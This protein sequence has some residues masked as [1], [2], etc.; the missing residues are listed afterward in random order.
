MEISINFIWVERNNEWQIPEDWD[1][2]ANDDPVSENLNEVADD[3]D[4]DQNLELIFNQFVTPPNFLRNPQFDSTFL[5]LMFKEGAKSSAT[6][7]L[8]PS[9]WVELAKKLQAEDINPSVI[10]VPH[11]M[12]PWEWY[13]LTEEEQLA[14]MGLVESDTLRADGVFFSEFN[15]FYFD[16]YRFGF[17]GFELSESI[18]L[19]DII[20]NPE[21]IAYSQQVI[22]R[23]PDSLFHKTCDDNCAFRPCSTMEIFP[24]SISLYQGD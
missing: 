11:G 7:E 21:F 13:A 5:N 17:A 9:R 10:A 24:A 4:S 23:G 15:S 1:P 20:K 18:E 16:T 3:W 8:F 12:T 2:N 14:Q 6:L 22:D 19:A